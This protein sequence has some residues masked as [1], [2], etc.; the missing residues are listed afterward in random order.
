[1]RFIVADNRETVCLAAPFA[2][3]ADG[4]VTV[5]AKF[6]PKA[7]IL[8][9]TEAQVALFEDALVKACEPGKGRVLYAPAG[10][11]P[12]PAAP[13]PEKPAEE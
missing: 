10:W 3:K 6:K 7:R 9:L 12:P 8:D 5:N 13:E 1:M 11:P 4:T 2:T